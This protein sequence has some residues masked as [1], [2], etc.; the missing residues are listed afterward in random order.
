[1]SYGLFGEDDLVRAGEV[2]AIVLRDYQQKALA[3]VLAAKDRGLNR[4]MVVMATGCGK[5]TVFA[6][7]VDQFERAYAAPSLVLAHRHELL[8]QAA[9]R[10]AAF[11]PRLQ[12]GIEGGGQSAPTECQVVVAGVQSI[13]RPDSKRLEWFHPGLMIIDEGHHTPAD[14]YQIAMRRFGSYDGSCFT[15]GVTATDH[16]MDNKPLHG[17]A[18]AIFEDVVFR[19]G[20][21]D[22]VREGWLVDLKGYR[23]ATDVDLS[24]IKSVGG[25]YNQGQ[26]ARAVNTQERNYTAYRHWREVAGDRR[27][28][29]FCVDVQHAKDVAELFR[30]NHVEAEHVDGTM[31]MDQ[32]EG[33]LRR[34]NSGRTQVLVN[35]DVA[36]EGFDAPATNCVLLLRPTQSWSL[37]CLDLET[38]VL[39][40]CG[41]KGWNEVG[42]GDEVAA[43]DPETHRVDWRTATGKVVRPLSEDETMVG[44]ESP[45]VSLRVSDRH[46]ML[47]RD[48]PK[49]RKADRYR[50]VE[51][52]ELARKRESY[53]IPVA[54]IQDAPGVPLTDDELRFVGWV[55][56]E[57]TINNA[58][59][60]ITITQA[61][62]QPTHAALRACLEGCGFK[63]RVRRVRGGTPCRESSDRLLYTLSHGK[64][65]GEDRHL[66]GWGRLQ[67]Y[68]DK[69]LS[70]LLEAVTP[71]QLGVLLEAIHLGDGS[72][73]EGKAWTRRTYHIATGNLV[74]AERLQSLCV[75][76]GYRCNLARMSYNKNPLYVLHI[77]WGGVRHIGGAPYTDRAH[78]TA[79]PHD[80]GER[81]WCL[82]NDWGTLVTRRRGKVVIVGNCQMVGRGLRTLGGTVDGAEA[83]QTRRRAIAESPKGDC[84]VIDVVDASKEFGLSAAP[85]KDNA[86]EP[87]KPKKDQ[88]SL[89]GLVGLPPEFDLQGNSLFAA[90]ERVEE[91]EPARKGALFRRQTNW[92]DLS[93]VLSEVDLIK[94]L[95]IPEEIVGVSGL[96]WMKVGDAEY[97]LPCGDGALEKDRAATLTT[98]ELGRMTIELRS[99]TMPPMRV[100]LG[101]D[102]QPA[103]D[104]A[105]RLI[106]MTWSDAGRIVKADARWRE[107][108]PSDRQKEILKNLG[109]P[110]REIELLETMHQARSLIERRRIGLRARSR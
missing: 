80:P 89:A 21:R 92:D 13:G 8:V 30:S 75:R 79:V 66:E 10:V 101:D 98:D 43:F 31:K 110:D 45:T 105:D 12:V 33:I 106:R 52:A 24:G 62:H 28:I 15:L 63:Y 67:G 88:A 18:G 104:E 56:T 78:L 49:G 19:F 39:T 23:V 5:T 16:R 44:V 27:T 42:V 47:F 54:G 14:S 55:I 60:Q 87:E 107:K 70:P 65:R 58:T 2:P 38:E 91:L 46:R 34:F 3:A 7:L 4:V 85:E 11:S 9:T 61:E 35:V 40:P 83:A 100:P 22:A 29:I 57:G 77:K 51:A 95:S 37:Y 82:E 26:L 76:R 96:A 1:M 74:F 48:R 97:W 71:A 93:T 109:V 108:P 59:R 84:I 64:P 86:D 73:Q 68:V 41:W 99:S 94:E 36:T 6:A 103:F 32:R 72:K 20:L 102:L 53:E 90:A 50:I 17:A 81:V 25:D 69:Q